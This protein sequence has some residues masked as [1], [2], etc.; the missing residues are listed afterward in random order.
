VPTCGLAVKDDT[1]TLAPAA[2]EEAHPHVNGVSPGHSGVSGL[3]VT[4]MSRSRGSLS[5]TMT[6][7]PESGIP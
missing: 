4:L 7:L 2:I 5:L 1:L 6:T 3:S